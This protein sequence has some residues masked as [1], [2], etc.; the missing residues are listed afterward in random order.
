MIR[1]S[2]C[3]RTCAAASMFCPS[4]GAALRQLGCLPRVGQALIGGVWL[5]LLAVLPVSPA[6]LW[7]AAAFA[8]G[9]VVWLVVLATSVARGTILMT[10]LLWDI[11][12][13]LILSVLLCAAAFAFL[14]QFRLG[15]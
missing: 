3:G 8:A 15:P 10:P 6:M 13:F 14:S 2:S 11:A 5:A 7:V 1:C 12:S 9:G 4:C